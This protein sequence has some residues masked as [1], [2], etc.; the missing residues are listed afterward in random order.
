MKDF[1]EKVD[2]SRLLKYALYLFL[3]LMA[4]NMVFGNIRILGVSPLLLPAA[5]AAVGMF[6]GPVFGAIFGLF[7]GYFADM[8]FVEN[9]VFFTLLLPA[10]AFASAFVS[11]FFVNRRFF[12]YLGVTLMALLAASF[13][14][15]LKT[16]AADVW[17]PQMLTTAIL[18]T[19]WSLPLAWLSYVF[20]A[21][22]NR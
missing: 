19:L 11:Q 16:M 2:F 1:L 21:K 9:S 14:Q 17:C 22:W 6:E 15:M 3:T 5:V 4:Q 20:P 7:M 12:A 18:Q 13:L 10:L 8:S